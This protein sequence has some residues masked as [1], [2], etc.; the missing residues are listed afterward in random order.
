MTQLFKVDNITIKGLKGDPGKDA[1]IIDEQALIQRI[2][3]GIRIPEDGKDA[4]VVDEEALIQRIESSIRIPENGK[5]APII[6]EKALIQRIESS[7]RIPEDG[8][9]GS[10]DTPDE[11]KEK[12]E[13]LPKGSRFDYDFLDNTPDIVSLLSKVRTEI[14]TKIPN[15]SSKTYS[16]VEL[17]DVPH[18]YSGQGGK[19]VSVKTDGSGLEFTTVSSGGVTSVSNSDGTLTVSPTTGAVVASLNLAKANTWTNTQTFN[20]SST[21]T[22]ALVV[23]AKAGSSVNSFEVQDSSGTALFD[24]NS[25][26]VLEMKSGVKFNNISANTLLGLT[27]G[28]VV[29]GVATYTNISYNSGINLLKAYP[30]GSDRNYQFNDGGTFQ[31]TD[32]AKQTSDGKSRFFTDADTSISP[33]NFLGAI[34]YGFNNSETFTT[35]YSTDGTTTRA[36]QL[37]TEK[38]NPTDGS[39]YW[40]AMPS[41]YSLADDNS[42]ITLSAPTGAINTGAGTGNYT[43]E[44]VVWAF[45]AYA[46]YNGKRVYSSSSSNTTNSSATGAFTLECDTY[47]FPTTNTAYGFR[48]LRSI[49][50]GT[51]YDAYQ[52]VATSTNGYFSD[53]GITGWVPLYVT[54]VNAYQSASGIYVANGTIRDYQVYGSF[55]VGGNQAYTFLGSTS[56]VSGIAQGGFT[57]DNLGG[58]YGGQIGWTA[59]TAPADMDASSFHYVILRQVNSGGFNEYLDVSG[60]ISVTS[61]LDTNDSLWSSGNTTSPKYFA[62]N[63]SSI[64]NFYQNVFTWDAVTGANGYKIL[65]TEDGGSTYVATDIAGGSTVTFTDTGTLAWADSTTVT[66]TSAGPFGVVTGGDRAMTLTGVL[67]LGT[68]P[69]YSNNASALAGGLRIGDVYRR[70][71]DPDVACIVH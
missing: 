5:D 57:D 24:V 16:F 32:Y 34:H 28:N 36:Y 22:K 66:P 38:V 64:K 52:D 67:N 43:G 11:I 1:P 4:P 41:N 65:K 8:K 3:A 7:I 68:T 55:T 13:S 30:S 39:K 58:F 40:S 53:D 20:P 10:P 27:F 70:S 45:Y 6:D 59:F 50:G 18:S 31:G 42:N 19:V 56:P 54:G 46:E 48:V 44:N 61:F 14:L 49:D 23:K 62:G 2:E 51:N 12:L 9:D 63:P 35:G 60:D 15:V 33:A 21:S 71:S 29:Q 69:E 37:Y 17:D 26:G 47:T 25:S